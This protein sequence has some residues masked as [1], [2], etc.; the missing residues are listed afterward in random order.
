MTSAASSRPAPRS[1]T[2]SPGTR[3][4]WRLVRLA[5]LGHMLHSRRF[6][7]RVAV[8]AIV[9]GGGPDCLLGQ[10]ALQ[11]VVL[12]G[13]AGG[14]GLPAPSDDVDPGAGGDADGVRGG[15]C[16]ERGRRRRW[17]RPR[18]GMP[19]VGGEVADGV[20]ELAGRPR[21]AMLA[22]HAPMACASSSAGASWLLNRAR[23]ARLIGLSRS[24]NNL[25]PAR[26]A[27]ARWARNW[28]QAATRCRIRSRRARTAIRSEIVAGVS[29]SSGR[30][31]ARSVH[32]VSAST[33]ESNRS[34]L[35]PA[36]PYRGTAGSSPA[37]R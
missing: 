27:T 8:G 7:E 12:G 17:P 33:S 1:Q 6:Y 30:S 16:R 26:N 25:V 36:E 31:Q 13:V 37:G 34:S 15:P 3:A 32:S 19:G 11:G 24:W 5:V 18:A 29:G 9:L 28:L 14:A 22:S 2:S 35:A 23:K 10:D 20:A 4:A 21:T